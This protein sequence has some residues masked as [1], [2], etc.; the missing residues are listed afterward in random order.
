[1]SELAEGL[2][3]AR[4]RGR[5]NKVR[6]RARRLG[7]TT[8]L[9]GVPAGLAIG[10][11]AWSPLVS[12]AGAAPALGT[13]S[14]LTANMPP[15]LGNTPSVLEL[16]DGHAYDLW[17]G[18]AP[19]GQLSTYYVATISPYG[20]AGQPQSIFGTHYWGG[21][22]W[23]PNLVAVGSSPLVIFQGDRSASSKDPYGA[24]CVVGALGPTIP[25]ALQT[26][27]LTNPCGEVGN[28]DGTELK[29]GVFATA[30]NGGKGIAFMLDQEPG[31]PPSP[32][33]A[34]SASFPMVRPGTIGDAVVVG[35]S[36]GN[37]DAYA[38]W[39][40]TFPDA[41]G[42]I[43]VKDL[44][45]NGPIKKVPGSGIDS[46]NVWPPVASNLALASTNT[47]G[48]V[49]LAYCANTTTS[50]TMQ[51]WRVGAAKAVKTPGVTLGQSIVG[52]KEAPALS[53]GPDGRLWLAWYSLDKAGRIFVDI[54]RTNEADTAFGPVSS[55]LSSCWSYPPL[56]G[57]GGG[58]WGRLDVAMQC[59]VNHPKIALEEFV[60]QTLVPLSVGPEMQSFDNSKAQAATFTVTDVGDPVPG[61]TVSIP[62]KPISATTGSAGKATLTLPKNMP[63]GQYNV[64]VTAPN[65]LPAKTHVVVTAPK[66]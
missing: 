65:Y 55:Y 64:I 35:D 29:T 39:S 56:I 9:I 24:G 62:G 54:T 60:T 51:L 31:I 4:Q 26:W 37:G 48:G 32:K 13:W 22:N 34:H 16:P 11:V 59:V 50:C 18:K 43:Y 19:G 36:A 49:Y 53:A 17:Y 12:P 41:A 52:F 21:L 30:R 14:E 66:T 23:Q 1:M 44:T 45:T 25:W 63:P 46:T 40:Q 47:H 15:L 27:S 2:R 33:L 42:G 38:A 28:G 20:V 3:P 7:R 6:D 8:A 58:G 61:A 10:A 57:L 5:S